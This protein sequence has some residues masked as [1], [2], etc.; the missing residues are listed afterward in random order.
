MVNAMPVGANAAMVDANGVTVGPNALTVGSNGVAVGPNANTGDMNDVAVGVN[1]DTVGLNGVNVGANA[2]TG[3]M[4]VAAVGL[5]ATA[6]ETNG[7]TVEVTNAM[8]LNMTL[9]FVK[10]PLYV[11]TARKP[12]DVKL[13]VA[14]AQSVSIVHRKAQCQVFIIRSGRSFKG[15]ALGGRSWVLP[16]GDRLGIHLP[17]A[18]TQFILQLFG[19]QSL[20]GLLV[21]LHLFARGP[22]VAYVHDDGRCG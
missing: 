11:P 17:A 12:E 21:A 4:N 13:H 22:F 14:M 3:G 10:A 20:I 1:D 9:P 8:M 19:R 2:I 6:V 15:C 5:N 18:K 16:A 7:S